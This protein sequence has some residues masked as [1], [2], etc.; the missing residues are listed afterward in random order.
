MCEG[1][2]LEYWVVHKQAGEERHVW[3]ERVFVDVWKIAVVLWHSSNFFYLAHGCCACGC[4]ARAAARAGERFVL[5]LT[6]VRSRSLLQTDR[7]FFNKRIGSP[8]VV[9]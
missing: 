3:F 2:E 8:S 5:T 9:S 6:N 4:S 1:I 7:C